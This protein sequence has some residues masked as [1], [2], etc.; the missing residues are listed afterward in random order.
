MYVTEF[1]VILEID[2]SSATFSLGKSFHGGSA[3]IW[4]GNLRETSPDL[5]EFDRG[6]IDPM[7]YVNEF[8]SERRGELL[9]LVQ[10]QRALQEKWENINQQVIIVMAVSMPR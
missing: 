6:T 9:T 8:L 1:G 7:I 4:G 2:I 3:M 10:L 5:V